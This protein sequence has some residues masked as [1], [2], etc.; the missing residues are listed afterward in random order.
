MEQYTR[1]DVKEIAQVLAQFNIDHISSSSLLSGGSE[2]TN[3]LIKSES[4]EYV[5]SIC[6][7]KTPKQAR[8]LAELLQHLRESGFTTSKVL[9][10][11]NEEYAII[12]KG[13]PI[14]VKEYIQGKIIKDLSPNLSKLLGKEL[15]KL[16]QVDVP[17]YV[18]RQ[19]NY[20]KEEFANVKKYAANSDF[21]VWL[22]QVLDYMSP[23]FKL[24]LPKA[25]I[26][27]D[28]FWDNVIV[29]A[30]ENSVAIMD[31]EEA[32]YYYRVFD[33]GMAVIGTCAEGEIINLEKAKYL[34]EG[35]QSEITLL[36]DEINS[37]KA[38]TIY[39]G[40]AMTFWR[41]QNFNYVKSDPK[42]FDHYKGLQ[43]LTDFIMMQDDDCFL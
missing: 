38:F 11:I 29:A 7:Q 2:N 34:L 21:E 28:L 19:V 39:A 16:H 9:L 23:Y 24:N 26:H 18:P 15:G 25:L 12:W 1:L 10:T 32:A 35:Y 31:F 42:M 36:E 20:G 43:V 17:K 4:G 30:G 22:S 6:E 33:V 37:L 41:H 3:Y 8:E 27:S 14:I 5:L 40:A 13:K